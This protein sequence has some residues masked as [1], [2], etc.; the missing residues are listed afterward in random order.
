MKRFLSVLSVLV[1]LCCIPARASCFDCDCPSGS[2]DA[3]L[4]VNVCWLGTTY[5]V[6]VTVCYKRY[7]PP[8]VIGEC[9]DDNLAQHYVI[10]I[11]KICPPVGS[12]IPL[13]NL[14]AAIQGKFDVCCGNFFNYSIPNFGD[15]ACYMFAIPKCWRM[16][17]ICWE[18][19]A[20]SKCCVIRVVYENKGPLA[21]CARIVKQTCSPSG[22]CTTGCTTW[23]CSYISTCPCP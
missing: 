2:S 9:N 23:E 10:K 5:V 13:A 6:P 22:E 21:P 18:P 7:S 8:S 3:T 19:C 4:N 12:G 17:G 14:I 15:V 20:D 11:K 1:L 16:V